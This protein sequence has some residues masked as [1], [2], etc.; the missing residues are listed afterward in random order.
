MKI[1]WPPSKC[2]MHALPYSVP[3]NLLQAT[4]NPHLHWRLL[5]TQKQ[6]WV[7]LLW[8][9]CSFP[10]GPGVH[11][12]LFVPSKSLFPQSCV[13]SGGSVMELMVTS[14]KRAYAILRSA[15]PRGPTPVAG[16]CWP[17][18]CRRHS[19]TV[20]AQSL[21]GLWVMVGTR[22]V[23]ALWASLEGKGFDSK[24]RFAPPT[25]L[26]G[27]LLCPWTW[28]IFFWWD[29]TFSSQWLFSSEL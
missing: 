6:V 20:L 10:L 2:S 19:N 12:F 11:K 8:H 13:N 5:D 29:P 21:W 22:F 27:L 4:I 3:L 24:H 26:L 16:H 15:V 1:I 7:S 23:W 17:Y 9:H 18:L 25:I 14:S 28:G